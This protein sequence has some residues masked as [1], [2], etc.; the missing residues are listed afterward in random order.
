MG[1]VTV[2]GSANID[3]VARIRRLPKEGETLSGEGLL[4]TFGGKGANQ[5]VAAARLGASVSF[6]GML[7]NDVYGNSYRERLIAEGID[8]THTRMSGELPTGSAF[9]FVDPAGSNT[10]V[11]IPS[12]NGR[13]APE[14]VRSARKCIT[15]TD[16]LMLQMEVPPETVVECIRLANRNSV[17]VMLNFSPVQADFKLGKNLEIDYLLINTVEAE[18]LTGIICKNTDRLVAAAEELISRGVKNVII[19]RGAET[20][21]L[22]SNSQITFLPVPIQTNP[23]DTVG[24]GDTFAGALAAALTQEMELAEAITYAN[25][26]AAISTTKQ[27]AQAS[28]P[29]KEEVKQRLNSIE[30]ALL[31]GQVERSNSGARRHSA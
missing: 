9:I 26:A 28:M 18:A 11:V 31:T 16:I 3:Y 6:I 2:A 23:V 22:D 1:R 21:F 25:C 14:H 29:S 5:A 17:P 24:A 12:A 19:T 20:T 15:D 13:L 30:N 7:G 27:G 8:T 10:I 4:I